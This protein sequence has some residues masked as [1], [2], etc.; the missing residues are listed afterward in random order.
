MR[1][2]TGD[3]VRARIA[4]LVLGDA[5]ET[6][7][8][9]IKLK[10][11]QSSAVRRIELALAEFGGALL[12]DE[13][14]MG[15]TY[16]GT[17][18]A[19]EYSRVIIVAPASLAGMWKHAL[20]ITG[21]RAELLSFERLSRQGR[22]RTD[23]GVMRPGVPDAAKD[24]GV[25]LLII[26]EAHHARN[27]T[28]RRYAEIQRL[29]RTA[30][31]LLLSATPIHNRRA[32]M[33]ALLSLF[34]GAR[35]KVLT[36]SELSRCVIRRQHHQV[37]DSAPIPKLLPPARLPV[38]DRPGIVRAL[39][40][41]PEALPVRDGGVARI[42]VGRGLVHQWAS[43]EAALQEAVAKRVA[44]ATALI[45]SLCAGVYPTE[46]EL[47]SWT[48]EEGVL[49]LGF[50]E[51]L[52]SPCADSAALLEYIRRHRDA[53]QDLPL[54]GHLCATGDAERAG[55]L[56]RIRES[57][58]GEKIVAFAQYAATVSMLFRRLL[59]TGRVALL[60]ARGARV[61]G[62]KLTRDDAIARFAPEALGV[63]PPGRAERVDLL[64]TTDLLSEGI[65]L[66][67]AGI[68]VHLDLPWTAARMEQRV[69][70][71]ARIGSMRSAVQPYIIGPPAS[72]A[73]VLESEA[74]IARKWDVVQ[75]VVGSARSAPVPAPMLAPITRGSES[76]SELTEVLRTT[77]EGWR[78]PRSQIPGPLGACVGGQHSGFLAVVVVDG[79]TRLVVNLGERVSTD[80]KDQIDACRHAS[81]PDT[82]ATPQDYA[83]ALTRLELWLESDAASA[84]AGT[85]DSSTI[86]RK[87]LLNRIDRETERAPPHVRANRL[88]LAAKARSVVAAQHSGAIED[89][90]SALTHSDL[91][92]EDW[93][94]AVA[95]LDSHRRIPEAK[96]VSGSRASTATGDHRVVL[97]AILLLRRQSSD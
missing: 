82:Y 84:V 95:R 68:V 58:P 60:T 5:P 52:A 25:D 30:R 90:L 53:L 6:F 42:L 43:S 22:S 64:L 37:D 31:V 97:H 91:G 93:L 38:T 35:A 41:L 78:R 51:L 33:V 24:R 19:A 83:R 85:A 87:H 26:D 70:R 18:I 32:D 10:R 23:T 88:L 12:C 48:F 2:V 81:G 11:H 45:A 67:D 62:G 69:G 89:E 61:A 66:Q 71:V 54:G 21:V 96:Q 77:L 20:S 29:A 44:R 15:K 76:P 56:L 36:A 4:Q 73:D 1:L 80:V 9:D 34:L 47:R 8:G 50:A 27:R 92:S 74:I 14:G 28:T 63:A 16:V 57:H 46:Q 59:R 7:L 39:L 13:V 17:A 49:Q 65:N 94:A 55:L 3:E 86:R 79:Q 40:A 72:A 75:S